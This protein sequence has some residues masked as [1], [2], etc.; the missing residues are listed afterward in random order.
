MLSCIALVGCS[1]KADVHKQ[2][3]P[4]TWTHCM[5]FKIVFTTFREFLL[6]PS[7]RIQH[8]YAENRKTQWTM[9]GQSFA[10]IHGS[11]WSLQ[12]CF[13][14]RFLIGS[15]TMRSIEHRAA[16]TL[17]AVAWGT[18][19]L[20]WVHSPAQL[21]CPKVHPAFSSSRKVQDNSEACF[22]SHHQGK[23]TPVKESFSLW[24]SCSQPL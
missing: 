2:S 11:T 23:L 22:L 5:F 9:L 15:W 14:F 1:I 16:P 4:T 12:R 24:P 17:S 21:C 7:R 3:S 10:E 19:G 20:L 13:S 6:Y 8:I 18:W